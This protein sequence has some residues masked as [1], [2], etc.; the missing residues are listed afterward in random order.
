MKIIGVIGGSVCSKEEYEIA[1]EVGKLIASEGHILL[2]GGGL[3]VME[4][5]SKGAFESGGLTVGIMP[6]SN[7]EE[8][9]PNPYIKIPIFTGMSDG[10]NSINV[11]SSDVVI[12]IGGGPGTLSE[13]ALALKNA[14]PVILLNSLKVEKIL[15]DKNL[16]IAKDILNLL[17]IL[18]NLFYI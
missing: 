18:K 3:G 13:I 1:Y 15:E 17:K 5:A 11:K 6:G 14:K 16:F 4:A 12:A 7:R 2:C 10:R 9:P 8:S